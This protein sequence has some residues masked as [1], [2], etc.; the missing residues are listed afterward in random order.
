MANRC[1]VGPE[2]N[3]NSFLGFGFEIDIRDQNMEILHTGRQL[4]RWIVLQQRQ[5]RCFFFFLAASLNPNERQRLFRGLLLRPKASVQNGRVE[6]PRV[7]RRAA[8]RLR[9]LADHPLDISSECPP[10]EWW[11][12]CPCFMFLVSH[13]SINR[14]CKFHVRNL[15]KKK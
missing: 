6:Y 9:K 4:W 12:L 14:N 8:G 15:F 10:L 11:V 1:I 13:I 5:N 3:P 2:L 7:I